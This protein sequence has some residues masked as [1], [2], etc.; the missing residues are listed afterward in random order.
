MKAIVAVDS[1]WGIG[2]KNELLQRI[3]E[4]M[5]FFKQTTLNKLLVMGRLTFESLPNKRPLKD[6]TNIVI[7]RNKDFK[8]EGLEIYYS[9]DELLFNL[10]KYKLNDIFII[11]G[12]SVYKQ[13]MPYCTQAYI[14][15]I[16]KSYT[17]DKY[18]PNLDEDK[19]WQLQSKGPIKTYKD[20]KFQFTTYK[21]NSVK[22]LTNEDKGV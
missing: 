8:S 18:F 14:T 7:S 5:K 4:D 11:G 21:N 1:N 20:I 13:F 3:P 2:Y 22:N 15:K 12:E 19:S 6:R 17:A 9:I 16:Y 10:K